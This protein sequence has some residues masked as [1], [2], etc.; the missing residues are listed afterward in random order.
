ML[1]VV[2]AKSCSDRVGQRLEN[3]FRHPPG[4]SSCGSLDVQRR[5]TDQNRKIGGAECS[6]L[7]HDEGGEVSN[8]TLLSATEAILRIRA[9]PRRWLRVENQSPGHGLPP[10]CFSQY[11]PVPDLDDDG[12]GQPDSGERGIAGPQFG[13]PVETKTRVAL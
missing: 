4:S 1:T 9:R 3:A 6:P 2:Q 13:G 10:P 5:R 7:R 8:V 12:S 11:E